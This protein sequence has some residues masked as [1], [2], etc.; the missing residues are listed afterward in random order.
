MEGKM[1]ILVNAD[2]QIYD[3]ATKQIYNLKSARRDVKK[4]E[5]NKNTEH[6]KLLVF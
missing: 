4:Y 3:E 6:N 2:I 1:Q 5:R